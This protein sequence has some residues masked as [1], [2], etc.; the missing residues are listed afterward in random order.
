MCRVDRNAIPRRQALSSVDLV[1]FCQTYVTGVSDVCHRCVSCSASIPA[2]HSAPVYIGCRFLHRFN[3]HTS[4]HSFLSLTHS[5][6]LP[7]FR[8]LTLTSPS[9]H[10]QNTEILGE[11]GLGHGEAQGCREAGGPAMLCSADSCK[12]VIHIRHLVIAIVLPDIICLHAS[13]FSRTEEDGSLG[14][15]R[16]LRGES[17]TLCGTVSS[18]PQC[19]QG[20]HTVVLVPDISRDFENTRYGLWSARSPRNAAKPSTDEVSAT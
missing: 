17:A 16:R 8:R 9:V 5:L 10:L 14:A 11:K 12:S 20:V 15:F 2:K 4:F 13:N 7:N 1:T 3:R 6:S 19:E 18:S